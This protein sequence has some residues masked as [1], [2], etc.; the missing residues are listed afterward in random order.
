MTNQTKTLNFEQGLEYVVDEIVKSNER[1]FVLTV[2]GQPNSG[3]SELRLQVKER[4]A[5]LGIY[6]WSG[7]QGDS[8][9]RMGKYFVSNPQY[10]LIEDVT[11]YECSDRF[12]REL[13]ARNPDLRVYMKRPEAGIPV[14]D[15]NDIHSGVYGFVIEN[16]HA[17]ENN[18]LNGK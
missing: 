15:F 10:V 8:S 3:K 2:I 16:P 4:L 6:G 5:T 17:T 1:P 12:S 13:F 18:K 11:T 14:N 9:E 7:M